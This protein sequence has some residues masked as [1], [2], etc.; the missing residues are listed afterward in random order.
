[1]SAGGGAT[2]TE[3][4]TSPIISARASGEPRQARTRA[5]PRALRARLRRCAL[6]LIGGVAYS[7]LVS[8]LFPGLADSRASPARAH[9][10]G[11]ARWFVA[12]QRGEALMLTWPYLAFLAVGPVLFIALSCCGR[13]Q[14]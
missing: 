14:P 12:L 10:N 2:I 13:G 8:L 11:P 6:A 3:R 4:K 1:M 5:A 7:F 9:A